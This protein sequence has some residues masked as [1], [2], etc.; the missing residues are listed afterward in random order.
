[1]LN[2]KFKRIAS[3]REKEKEELNH[4]VQETTPLLIRGYH[5]HFS[6]EIRHEPSILLR[7]PSGY[8]NPNLSNSCIPSKRTICNR[9]TT[10]TIQSWIW[11]G[12]NKSKQWPSPEFSTLMI[13]TTD[14]R[15]LLINQTNKLPQTLI[16]P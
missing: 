9:R 13:N 6:V 2:V 16:V 5:I 4:K 11:K 14:L 3:K 15:Y 12:S 1:M 8:Y 7:F 10:K